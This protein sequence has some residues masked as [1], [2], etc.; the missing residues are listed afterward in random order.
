METQLSNRL[1]N[2]INTSNGD[3]GQLIF[4][5]KNL[6]VEYD[7][8]NEYTTNSKSINE[9]I[10]DAIRV[11][12]NP[13]KAD[14]LITTQFNNLN[15]LI[16]G[17]SLGE[18]IVIGGRPGMGKTQFLINLATH[19]SKSH[20]LLFFSFDLSEQ[21]LSN[22]FLSVLTEIPTS[23]LVQ[24][25]LSNEEMS[26]LNTFE[27]DKCEHQL[28]VNDNRSSSM[29]NIKK[30]CKKQIEESGIK[31]IMIDYLQLLTANRR[32]QN[33]D[34][35]ISYVCRELKNLATENNVCIIL[36]SQLSRAVETRGGDRKPHL[37]DLRDSGAIEQDADKVLFIY[38]PE[39]YGFEVDEDNLPTKGIVK[40]IT[41]KNRM[42][43]L[44]E[45]ILKIDDN[46]IKF[47]EP[48]PERN[49]FRFSSRIDEIDNDYKP[50]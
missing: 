14:N 10:A 37:S 30:Y 26:I 39:Y 3:D 48:E 17:F 1:A 4:H 44:G 9:L 28:L 45:T 50:F 22:R 20:P 18:L 21:L 6:I 34:A 33:R 31:V 13:T 7:E 8:N 24:N 38:R 40:I 19:I 16:N 47:F 49:T 12:Q 11:I 43:K 36:S 46:F 29:S 25:K 41:A 5:L 23:N 15:N 32:G 42:G 27:I 2:I 35:E